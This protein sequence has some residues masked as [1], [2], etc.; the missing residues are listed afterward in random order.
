VGAGFDPPRFLKDGDVV[1]I[2]IEGVGELEN[3]V[4]QGRDPQPVGLELP[5]SSSEGNPG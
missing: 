3:P 1:R 4:V 5:R 2:A